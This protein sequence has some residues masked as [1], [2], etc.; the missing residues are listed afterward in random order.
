MRRFAGFQC[1]DG[2]VCVDVPGDGCDPQNGG[3]DCG[4]MCVEPEPEGPTCEG[5][6]GGQSDGACWCDDLCEGF[7]DCCDD[8][9]AACT[10]PS[11][12]AARRPAATTRSAS[13]T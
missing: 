9:E 6:C 3:A 13:P 8:Y 10:A 11:P 12:T 1:P 2:L 7:G 5:H 4:G